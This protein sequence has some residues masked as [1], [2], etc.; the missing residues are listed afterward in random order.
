MIT[1]FRN[2]RGIAAVELALVAPILFVLLA[3]IIEGGIVYYNHQVFTNACREG[4]RAGIR[5]IT[6]KLTSSQI[7]DVVRNYCRDRL[8]PATIEFDVQVT[9]DRGDSLSELEVEVTYQYQPL[10]FPGF[11]GNFI[12]QL[13]TGIK[14]RHE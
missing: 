9:G 4:A 3:V 11:L 13:G 7:E 6:S 2:C 5:D 14:M 10:F 12:G 1:K 8:V